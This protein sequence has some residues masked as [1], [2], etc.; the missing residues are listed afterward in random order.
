MCIFLF[1]AVAAVSANAA[2]DI[3]IEPETTLSIGGQSELDRTRYFSIATGGT[4]FGKLSDEKFD[5]YINELGICFGRSV[6]L[7]SSGRWGN[8][9]REDSS[10]PGYVDLE[11]LK[12]QV[13]PDEGKNAER[14]KER[15][16]DNLH[17]IGTENFHPKTWPDFMETRL[18]AEDKTGHHP[19]AVNVDAA[20]EGLIW[21][22]RITP[23][24]SSRRTM[25]RT[26]LEREGWT[27]SAVCMSP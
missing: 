6:N 7:L 1:S 26:F 4:D 25:V 20:A 16:P 2:V 23:Y 9:V 15:F 12:Q 27:S 17:V 13:K 8:T 10:R 19:M 5:Y 11:Y 18:L 21:G 24:S 22:L 14:L 3:L